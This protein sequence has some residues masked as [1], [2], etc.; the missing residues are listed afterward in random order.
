MDLIF[1]KYLKTLLICHSVCN[2]RDF[3]PFQQIK[4]IT[5][6]IVSELKLY[7][8]YI[9]INQYCVV[10]LRHWSIIALP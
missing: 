9:D 5:I 4:I 1:L 7:T 3:V 8:F 10:L 2:K 6:I